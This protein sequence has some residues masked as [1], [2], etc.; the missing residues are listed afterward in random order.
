MGNSWSQGKDFTQEFVRSHA[1]QIKS[2]L[3]I[4]PGQGT[5]FH[6][7][8]DD[9]PD[10]WWEGV[11]VFLPYI[12][13][14]KLELFYGLIHHTDVRKF[15]P[16]RDYDLV[17]AGDVLEHMTKEQAEKLVYGMLPRC[18]YF[19]ISIPIV[20]WPQEA[21][22]NNPYEIHVKDDWSHDEMMETFR[23]DITDAYAGSHI[24]VYILKGELAE[25]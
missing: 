14:F 10:C 13:G 20:H 3:D 24:G 18:K 1:N 21:I 12:I 9:L 4:G 25:V 17:I 6:L 8:K 16:Q 2:V 15:Q 22:N 11:E 7:L 19:I 23:P 5:Y